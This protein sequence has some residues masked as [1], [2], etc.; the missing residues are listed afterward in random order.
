MSADCGICLSR[1]SD[2]AWLQYQRRLE[3]VDHGF[4]P[5]IWVFVVQI[6]RGSRFSYGRRSDFQK[7]KWDVSLVLYINGGLDSM[8]LFISQPVV[9]VYLCDLVAVNWIWISCILDPVREWAAQSHLRLI[10]TPR[11]KHCG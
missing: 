2:N 4:M 10:G 8:Q 6:L 9:P 7:R 5:V 11:R 1:V 3:P